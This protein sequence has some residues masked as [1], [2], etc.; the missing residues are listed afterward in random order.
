M[1]TKYGIDAVVR[2][3]F[4]ATLMVIIAAM[5]IRIEILRYATIGFIG[6]AMLLVLNFFRDP[7]RS[8][9][10]DTADAVLSPADGRIVQIEDVF[11][12]EYLKED[13]VQVS[14]FMSPLD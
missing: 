10:K 7:E 3:F 11:E 12:P 13:A 4:L 1:I 2:Y 14:I 6:V 8:V 5:F 9:P